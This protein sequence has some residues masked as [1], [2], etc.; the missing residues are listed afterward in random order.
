[1][2]C[3]SCGKENNEGVSFCAYCGSSMLSGAGASPDSPAQSGQP[4]QIEQPGSTGYA[5]SAKKARSRVDDEVSVGEWLLSYL[6][7]II[8]IPLLGIIML[9]VWALD[10]NGP[11]S[12]SN[13]AKAMLIFLVIAAIL[14]FLIVTVTGVALTG[15]ISQLF[16][17]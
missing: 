1:M 13:W 6:I 10:K 4:V 17:S 3:P 16:G 8:P 12:K 5:Q 14:A 15:L 11:R 2:F 7:L 9:I